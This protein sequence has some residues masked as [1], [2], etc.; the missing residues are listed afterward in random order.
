VVV[1]VRQGKGKGDTMEGGVLSKLTAD[2]ILTGL[3]A[4]L[5]AEQQAVA[6][7]DAHAEDTDDPDLKGALETLRDVEREHALRLALRIAALEG[8]PSS[9]T[10]K[11]QPGGQ[12]LE[13]RLTKDLEGE[14]WA[15]V[16]YARLVAGIIE[17]DETADLMAELL[18]DEIRHAAWLKSVLRSL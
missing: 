7:Y 11:P 5:E 4:A 17:D 16:E 12:T 3:N 8:T 14:Q 1:Q 13:A 6:D 10:A 18:L 15:I 2:E 9:K